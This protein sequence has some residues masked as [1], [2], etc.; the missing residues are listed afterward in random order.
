AAEVLE[1]VIRAVVRLEILD[2]RATADTAE[3]Q[4]LQLVVTGEDISRIANLDIAQRA[5]VVVRRRTAEV[6][7]VDRTLRLPLAVH[8]PRRRGGS[9][10]AVRDRCTTEQHHAAP[11][12]LRVVG[13]KPEDVVAAR[14]DDR[15]LCRTDRI[16]LITAIDGEPRHPG[17]SEDH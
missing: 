16:D 2:R 11:L 8:G 13:G 17:L 10:R 4:G 3:R 7:R 1:S 14:E 15:L 6:G 12:T 9:D 5:A